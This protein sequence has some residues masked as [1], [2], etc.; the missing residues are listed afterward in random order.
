MGRGDTFDH[1]RDWLD[2]TVLPA[3]DEEAERRITTLTRQLARCM[4]KEGHFF[5]F[6]ETVRTMELSAADLLLVKQRLY[7]LA[8]RRVLRAFAISE[9][10]RSGLR[11]IARAVAL[12]D[13]ECRRIESSAGRQIF[14]LHLGFSMS[15]GFLD[16]EELGQVRSLAASLGGTTHEMFAAYLADSGAEF[17]ERLLTGLAEGEGVTDAWWERFMGTIAAL[18]M[19]A[20]RF[21]ETVRPHVRRAVERVLAAGSEIDTRKAATTVRQLLDRLS[22]PS[23]P[24]AQSKPG[25]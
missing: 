19:D 25:S 15:A 5:D 13:E 1:V 20:E 18:G 14:E 21:R 9:K 6:G 2:A 11:W 8:V 16:E 22:R 24:I 12:S 3:Q 17:V 4:R 7:E 23:T 10:D